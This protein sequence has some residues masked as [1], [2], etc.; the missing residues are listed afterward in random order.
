MR[1]GG[2]PPVRDGALGEAEKWPVGAFEG[3]PLATFKG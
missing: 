2:E 1:E 3:S